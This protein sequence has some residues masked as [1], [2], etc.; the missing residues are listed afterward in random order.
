[1]GEKSP[2]LPQWE[3]LYREAEQIEALEPW[4]LLWDTDLVEVMVPGRERPVYCAVLG[5]AG[6]NL[7]VNVYDSTEGLERLSR[8]INAPEGE[9]QL[10]HIYEQEFT[11]CFFGPKEEL[12][13]PDL[14]VL[15]Q[16]GRSYDRQWIYFRSEKP[17]YIPW[18]LDADQA[19]L[20]TWAL[21]GLRACTQWLRMGKIQAEYDRER[22]LSCK[23][24]GDQ[25]EITQT[26]PPEIFEYF[27]RLVMEEEELAPLRQAE[28][29]DMVLELDSFYIPTPIQP[30]PGKP[31]YFPRATVLLNRENGMCIRQET[32]KAE[33][34]FH[35]T[36]LSMVSQFIAGEGCPATICI[37]DDR[38]YGVV[39]DLCQ[40][41]EI[42]LMVGSG[43]PAADHYFNE[44]LQCMQ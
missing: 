21:E 20:M 40:V 31:G 1:M 42:R 23:R 17:G 30:E 38:L 29:L 4:E 15:K 36:A 24:Q 10:L 11:G 14:S 43:M 28:K 35:E 37:R 7:G 2:T 3:K 9:N 34:D 13:V 26:T 33:D 12:M 41:L 27:P 25:W 39:Y 6:E 22:F 16:L 44:I 5:H 32:G 19:E 8:L 18:Y